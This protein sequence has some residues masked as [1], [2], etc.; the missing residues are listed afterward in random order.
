MIKNTL[1]PISLF[2]VTGIALAA[3]I[4]GT[5][6]APTPDTNTSVDQT[7]D[8]TFDT[9]GKAMMTGA[10]LRCQMANPETGETITYST[11]DKKMHVTTAST[12]AENQTSYMINDTQ[13]V[14]IWTEG[15][16][17]GVKS[18]VPTEAEMKELAED[19]PEY[20]DQDVTPETPD[21]TQADIQQ[22]YQ[23]QGYTLDCT[24][25]T[26]DDS[27]FIP[28]TTVTFQDMSAMMDGALEAAKRMNQPN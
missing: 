13:F 11:K 16:T 5:Q 19:M 28:P 7:N 2:L 8:T 12:D 18:P 15:E 21:F 22:E 14:Y 24:P 10:P 9:L 26:I 23:D 25:T 4:P 1:T 17:T 20:D 27:E 3:C 6:P